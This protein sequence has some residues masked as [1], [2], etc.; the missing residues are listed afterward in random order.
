MYSIDSYYNPSIP[1]AQKKRKTFTLII[2]GLI[3]VA[4]FEYYFCFRQ[5]STTSFLNVHTDLHKKLPTLI[6]YLP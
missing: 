1:Y 2:R 4:D 6:I 5:F 3:M